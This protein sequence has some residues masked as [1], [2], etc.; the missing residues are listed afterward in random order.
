MRPLILSLL[1]LAFA[2]STARADDKYVLGKDDEAFARELSRFGYPDLASDLA[3]KIKTVRGTA[4]SGILDI[5]LKFDQAMRER[6]V[7]KRVALL[8]EVVKLKEAFGEQNKG[9]DVG[10]EVLQSLPDNYRV[11][12]ESI[13]AAIQTEQDPK[14]VEQMRTD[15]HELFK[16]AER[17]LNLSLADL[18]KKKKAE[19]E[20]AVADQ[21]DPFAEPEEGEAAR[22]YKI[23]LYSQIRTAY[24]HA[25]LLEPTDPDRTVYLNRALSQF[26]EFQFD[27]AQDYLCYE[28]FIYEGLCHAALGN[29][30]AAISSFDAALHLRDNF[31]RTAGS[32]DLPKEA[33]DIVSNAALQKM[34]VLSK[35][36][37]DKAAIATADDFLNTFRGAEGSL[38]GLAVLAAKADACQRTGDTAALEATA[39]KL[40]ELDP[41]G[42]GG[43]KAKELL[44]T[45][46][47]AGGGG[48]FAT[49]SDAEKAVQ[50]GELDLAVSMCQRVLAAAR[51]SK[52]QQ[53]A[54]AQA[55]LL[56]G[57]VQAQQSRM[58]EAVVAWETAFDRFPQG[59]ATPD[60]LWRAANG[61]LALFQQEARGIYKARSRETLQKLVDK[62]PKSQNA[63]MAVLFDVRGLESEQKFLEAAK[64]AEA[65][66][67]NS[68]VYGEA[69]YRA[70][71][72]YANHVRV[73]LSKDKKADV[74]ALVKSA[75]DR[76]KSARTKLDGAAK[77]TLDENARA[78]LAGFAFAA[79]ASLA[80]LYLT[81]GVDR[82]ADVQPLLDGVETQYP[83]DD[84]K[85]AAAWG[86]RIRALQDLGK[87][88]DAIRQLD[89]QIAKD[90]KTK[91][92]G[93]AAAAIG[94][95]IDVRAQED[96]KAKGASPAVDS[97]FQRAMK[98]YLLGIAPQ[99]DGREPLR[100]DSVES[101]ADRLYALGLQFNAVPESVV[102]WVDWTGKRKETAAWTEAARLYEVVVPMTP[103][104]R[105]LIHLGQ[106]QAYLGRYKDAATTYAQLFDRERFVDPVRKQIDEDSLRTRP[107]LLG[108]YVEFGVASREAG[109]AAR[110]NS[111][112][113]RASGVFEAIV[114]STARDS[115]A[116]WQAKFWQIQLMFDRGI[117]DIADVAMRS[118]R[119]GS[120]NFDEGKYGYK[121]RLE[122]LELEI[123]A[124][125]PPK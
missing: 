27:Y 55:C 94:R 96:L 9:T 31:E 86:L 76:L 60:A 85:L 91:G 62:Y 87:V 88:D 111:L 32:W 3:A 99:V 63:Q 110:D 47:G 12:G 48:L 120:E 118:V 11:I 114:Q 84:E 34:M 124:K 71:N 64:A 104:Y 95:A 46:G 92:I 79:R 19:E 108:A 5:D 28:G 6:D 121:D 25:L 68:P 17:A 41:Q 72:D 75:E 58:A 33:G 13:A 78:R 65:I 77:D 102:S 74:K 30:D 53:S 29:L 119:R 122:K 36:G 109:V 80:N 50:R 42:L 125:L 83:G 66:A 37:D 20:K 49:L 123:K 117:Y 93:P 73:L 97:Q 35:K 59:E 56:I 7:K 57:I 22:K 10:D 112:L 105:T 107:E 81:D 43:Q 100:V 82:A 52:D 16:R 106:T 69:Q 115:R 1:V 14:A 90:P 89:A 61:Y 101:V 98:Y 44:G 15:G 21:Q 2:A 23:T 51:G 113:E 67:E 70:G 116:W 39:K 8:M 54:S 40:L 38:K 18:E 24:F 26:Q 4:T 45:G 103:S